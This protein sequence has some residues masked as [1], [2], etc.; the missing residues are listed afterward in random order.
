MRH[1]GEGAVED[2]DLL[3][4][5]QEHETPVPPTP[6][7]PKLTAGVMEPMPANFMSPDDMLRAYAESRRKAGAPI[8]GGPTFPS[9]VATSYDGNGMRTLYSPPPMTT[10]LVDP[11]PKPRAVSEYSRYSDED[12]Y[13]GTAN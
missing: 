10:P 12:A 9:P 5:P 13:M 3:F 4:S 7:V 2:N 6:T 11:H 1:G 8:N